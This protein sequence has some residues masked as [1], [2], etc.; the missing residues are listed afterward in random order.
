MRL[1]PTLGVFAIGVGLCGCGGGGGGSA[2]PVSA[3]AAIPQTASTPLP[4]A[5]PSAATISSTAGV[6]AISPVA[7]SVTGVI[8]PGSSS[9]IVAALSTA[10]VAGVSVLPLENVGIS[11][12]TG[13]AQAHTIAPL[14]ATALEQNSAPMLPVERFAAEDAASIR[15]ALSRAVIT[16]GAPAA[17]Q[18]QSLPTT[19]GATTS[20]WIQTASLGAAGG[21]F[22]QLGAVLAAITA[23][24]YI[25]IDASLSTVLGSPATIAAIANDFENAYAS[26]TAHF[27]SAQYTTSAAGYAA[28]RSVRACDASGNPTG[29]STPLY[30]DDA[31]P[32]IA[33]FVANTHSLGSGV[34]GYFNSA[35][36]WTT[37]AANCTL[38]T[39]N[40]VR[41]NAVPMI[42]VGYEP[43][44]PAGYPK[45]YEITEDL[46]RSTA[47]E[48]QHL[49]NFIDHVAVS[50]VPQE[51][52]WINEGLSMLAQDL[53]V[54]RLAG[55]SNDV[56]DAAAH[57][58]RYLAAPQ[59]YSIT[60]FSGID[61]THDGGTGALQYNCPSCYGAEYLF[62]RYLYDRFGGDGFLRAMESGGQT[63]YANIAAATGSTVPS[64][65]ADFG[66]ALVAA[67]TGITTDPRYG[68]S[69]IN[70]Q[71][72]LKD[73]FGG[74]LTLTGPRA[75]NS[76]SPGGVLNV[77]QYLGTYLYLGV[78]GLG[79][80][81]ATVTISD[82]AGQFGLRAAIVRHP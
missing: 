46:V 34:G 76:I 35:N 33:V 16:S 62:E 28:Y 14:A 15:A 54:P 79:S 77:G 41:T 5:P 13:A 80:S 72:S 66:I 19:V 59:N 74:T 18:A 44:L 49:I 20:L 57:A 2:M 24:G 21:S 43:S 78:A 40:V 37:A 47:H 58:A 69:G 17:R 1:F 75:A 39:A 61:T 63:S 22:A 67:N 12:A 6:I 7:N 70:L 30:I 3:A 8:A 45:D 31:D 71:S 50:N 56:A 51:D 81:G 26:D 36:F 64:L 48:L 68:F 29:Q 82:P 38:G 53:A 23:H 11:L 73:Q 60:G 25:W 65:L 10:E 55:T 52:V 27:G 42:Y 32:R 9:V 4:S